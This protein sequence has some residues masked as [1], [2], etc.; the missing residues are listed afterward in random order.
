MKIYFYLLIGIVLAITSDSAKASTRLPDHYI[1]SFDPYVGIY[2]DY[3]NNPTILKKIEKDLIKHGYNPDIDY[4]S[5]IGYALE[6][7]YPDMNRFARP[8]TTKDRKTWKW[9]IAKNE[10]LFS[11]FNPWPFGQPDLK[12]GP[13]ASAQILAKPYSVTALKQTP[14]DSLHSVANHTYLLTIT[15]DISNGGHN[16]YAKEWRNIATAGSSNFTRFNQ[17]ESEVFEDMRQFNNKFKFI[18]LDSNRETPLSPN[19][20]Y[21]IIWH[22]LIPSVQPSIHSATTLPSPLPLQRVRGGFLLDIDAQPISEEYKISKF[23]LLNAAGDTLV[24]S[25]E[26]KGQ[27]H[28]SSQKLS[29]GDSINMRMNLILR[30]GMYNGILLS[31]DNPRYETGLS[32]SQIV[33]LSDDSKILGFIPLSDWLWWWAP[34]N[35]FLAVIIWDII[36]VVITIGI[37]LIIAYRWLK[38]TAT[39][40]PD[41]KTISITHL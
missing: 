17:I 34:N 18:T 6:M 32:N 31:P 41:D 38:K 14:S 37:I 26:A 7:G 24:N 4:I 35:P 23:I 22:E 27:F 25:P 10:N 12:N 39:Y 13:A 9:H 29:A 8:Y 19:G 30:D 16:D 21:R 3:Y 5:V 28:I 20:G 11:A 36:I 2:Q 40:I 33:K 15:D 1:I